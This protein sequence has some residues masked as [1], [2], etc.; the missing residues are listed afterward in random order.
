MDACSGVTLHR[1]GLFAE[2]S[3]SKL[4]EQQR[5]QNMHGLGHLERVTKEPG[6]N[7]IDNGPYY[8]FFWI[9]GLLSKCHLK[10]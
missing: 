7:D 6:L 4:W 5:E 2:V 1:K 10:M 8:T 3:N 9:L